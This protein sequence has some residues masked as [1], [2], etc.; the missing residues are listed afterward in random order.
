MPIVII[1]CVLMGWLIQVGVKLWQKTN[2][3]NKVASLQENTK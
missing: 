2:G 1:V 3:N